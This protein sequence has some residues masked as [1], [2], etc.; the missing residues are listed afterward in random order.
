MTSIKTTA[1]IAGFLYLLQIPLGV[2]GILYVPKVLIVPGN[3]AATASN[4]LA[5]EFLFRLGIVSTILCAL[6]TVA[7]A[8][9]IYKV[10]R[11]VNENYAKWILLFTLIVAPISMLNELNSIA[12][13]LLL[14]SQEFVNI[15]TPGQL[16]S[17]VS[18]FLD[19]HKYG[20][21]IAGIFFGLWLLPMGYL[22]FKS[23][24]IPKIIGVFLIVTSLSYLIDF[25]TFFLY[26]DFPL[27]I[28][29]YTWL[30]EVLMVLW[31]LIKGVNVE[32]FE[33]WN[34]E[35]LKKQPERT[36]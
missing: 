29:E 16:Q 13:L 6:V 32:K 8:L 23:T 20:H 22:V 3:M 30:G 21:Q 5:N 31:L 7:T 4:I 34:Q 33:K 26:P 25:T 27:T 15:F 18:V 11:Y 1:R 19:L 24:Y 35:S 36:Q 28:S 12:V 17:L 2:F 14:K 10:L 9:Y